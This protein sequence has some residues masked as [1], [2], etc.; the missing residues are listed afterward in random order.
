MIPASGVLPATA[1]AVR[2]VRQVAKIWLPGRAKIRER[3]CR[4]GGHVPYVEYGAQERCLERFDEARDPAGAEY[5]KQ[6]CRRPPA[7]VDE[8]HEAPAPKTCPDC[9]VAVAVDRV[10]EQYQEDVPDVRPLV[11]RSTSRWAVARSAGGACRPVPPCRPPMRSARPE[12]SL[13]PNVAVLTAELHT[14]SGLPLE[15]PSAFCG[16]GSDCT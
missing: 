16:P 5:G 3:V 6:G 11:R 13:G 9:A 2:P 8:T 4:Y 15:R 14:E 12:C 7:R 1:R 10:A